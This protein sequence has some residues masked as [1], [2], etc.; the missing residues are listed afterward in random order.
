MLTSQQALFCVVDRCGGLVLCLPLFGDHLGAVF[1]VDRCMRS[2]GAVYCVHR[3][4]G[5]TWGPCSVDHSIGYWGFCIV[6]TVH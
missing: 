3:C 1:C 6:L 5:D 2:P 4:L